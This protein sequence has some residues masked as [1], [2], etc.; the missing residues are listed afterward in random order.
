M[1]DFSAIVVILFHYIGGMNNNKC[2]VTA[3]EDMFMYLISQACGPVFIPFIKHI[4]GRSTQPPFTKPCKALISY[5]TR[6]S[7]HF[8]IEF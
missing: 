1:K 2:S 6:C 4:N 7:N 3:A 5:R 8:P